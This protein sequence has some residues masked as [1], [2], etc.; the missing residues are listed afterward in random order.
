ML[1]LVYD[2]PLCMSSMWF[3]KV[4]NIRLKAIINEGTANFRGVQRPGI[5]PE[6]PVHVQHVTL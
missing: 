1:A 5:I 4:S 6:K 2:D 3:S